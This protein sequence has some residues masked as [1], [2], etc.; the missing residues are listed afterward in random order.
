MTQSGDPLENAIAERTNG[1]I[2]T[3]WLYKV[4]IKTIEECT[5]ELERIALFYNTERPHRSIGMQ[6][7]EVAYRQEGP[8]R[9]CWR[10]PWETKYS[11]PDG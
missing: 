7:P 3:E 8:Q 5:K 2:K 9:R 6:T 1:I 4:K 10:N 11:I